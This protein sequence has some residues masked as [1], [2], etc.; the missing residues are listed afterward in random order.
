M[1]CKAEP[2]KLGRH[3][4]T[5]RRRSLLPADK[6][7][8]IGLVD[9]QAIFFRRRRQ[10]I[11]PPSAARAQTTLPRSVATPHSARRRLGG[12]KG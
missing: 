3:G 12:P 5:A 11:R 10:P 7:H 6:R 4:F 1:V 9:V 8:H 2:S